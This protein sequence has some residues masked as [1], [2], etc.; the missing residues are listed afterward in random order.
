MN[1]SK[2]L[3]E[4]IL[5]AVTEETYM[6]LFKEQE[7]KIRKAF[8]SSPG[9]REARRVA[10]MSDGLFQR[11]DRLTL[12][13]DSLLYERCNFGT[14]NAQG[15]DIVTGMKL[16]GYRDSYHMRISVKLEPICVPSIFHYEIPLD[17]GKADRM[18]DQATM[19]AIGGAVKV[20]Q[21]ALA[22]VKDLKMVLSSSSTVKK[23]LEKVPDAT[24]TVE[25]VMKSPVVTDLKGKITEQ[26]KTFLD[27]IFK[28]RMS[29][30]DE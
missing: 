18:F 25:K 27:D 10:E 30:D 5:K 16:Y 11:Y 12:Y 17:D 20:M 9:Y 22:F 15:F 23:F 26:E 7:E 8:T 14:T 4:K 3:R 13:V 6:P 1:L 21:D 2:E 19:D 24:D 29:S 28:R